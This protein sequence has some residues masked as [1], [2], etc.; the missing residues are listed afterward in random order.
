MN[1]MDLSIIILNY[2]SKKLTFECLA[3][4]FEADFSFEKKRL[5]Y[6]VI[7]I[8]NNSG[9]NIGEELA[10]KYPEVI[11]IQNN[12]NIGMGA[13]NNVGIRIAKGNYIVIMNPDT[14]VFKDT[15]I[16]LYQF[17]EENPEVGVVGPKQYNPDMTVQDSCYRWYGLLTPLYRR[18]PLGK[19][20]IAKKDLDRFLMK[21][22]DHNSP[23][24]VDWLL[25][26]FLFC[27]RKALKEVG[28]FDD[29]FFLYFEDTDLCRRFWQAGWKVVYYPE[30]KIIHNHQRQSA[31][32]VWYKFFLN[33]ASREHVISWLKYLKKWGL[34]KYERKNK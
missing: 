26:S 8:D 1:N 10:S 11:F 17:M 21:D 34:R 16:R 22:F 14:V 24:E 30:A 19:L 15:F 13:G 27:R 28:F 23:K 33:K 4:I 2:R 7:V 31:K 25:G 3:S 20:K 5:K 12:R 6:E 29:R 9:D 32:Q 18:T